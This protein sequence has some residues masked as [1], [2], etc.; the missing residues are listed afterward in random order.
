M[1][2]F[3]QITADAIV[4]VADKI[5]TKKGKDVVIVSLARAGTPLGILIRRVHKKEI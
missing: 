5:V 3:G 2:I 1:N 4:R